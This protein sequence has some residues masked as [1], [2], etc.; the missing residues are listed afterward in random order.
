MGDGDR[1]K[2]N[3]CGWY[4]MA[5]RSRMAGTDTGRSRMTD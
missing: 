1:C 5:N 3:G 4:K 2:S